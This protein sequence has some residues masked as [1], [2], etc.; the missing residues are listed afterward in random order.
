MLVRAAWAQQEG[1]RAGAGESALICCD[2]PLTT[3]Q[4][5]N[6][7]PLPPLQDAD[8]YILD[9]PLSAVDVHV[10]RH[11]FDKFITGACME[12]GA[13]AAALQA[14]WRISMDGSTHQTQASMSPS[15]PPRPT[16]LPSAG[17]AAGRTR[18][19]VTNQLQYTPYADRVVV[20][21]DGRIVTQV[22]LRT[23]REVVRIT[24]VAVGWGSWLGCVALLFDIALPTRPDFPASDH[25]GPCPSILRPSPTG[26]VRRVLLQRRVC[27]PAARAQRRPRRR[28]RRGRG[29]R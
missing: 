22:R 25:I 17:A 16:Y 12:L 26:H 20:I 24:G 10:G 23:G 15:P 27:P 7:L 18:L 8:V 28:G 1:G 4:S 2:A 3:P 14:G 5:L 6:L 13:E 9:D 29:H 19:L 11:I 21:D